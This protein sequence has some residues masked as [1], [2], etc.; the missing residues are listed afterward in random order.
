MGRLAKTTELNNESLFNGYKNNGSFNAQFLYDFYLTDWKDV[1]G[2]DNNEFEKAGRDGSLL[3]PNFIHL[4]NNFKNFFNRMEQLLNWA[5]YYTACAIK[6]VLR[7][8]NGLITP[9]TEDEKDDPL[10]DENNDRNIPF[11]AIGILARYGAIIAALVA[12]GIISRKAFGAF[13]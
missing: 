4:A 7:N 6:Y 2:V 12:T 9:C 1:Y 11:D 10:S 8:F 3:P 5:V 13:R